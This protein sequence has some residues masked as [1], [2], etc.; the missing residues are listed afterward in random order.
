M[1]IRINN[2]ETESLIRE[3]AHLRGQGI[4]QAL[5]EVFH[6]EVERERRKPAPKDL[7]RRS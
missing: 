5:T 7:L 1:S 4:T 2:P 3:L 6:R